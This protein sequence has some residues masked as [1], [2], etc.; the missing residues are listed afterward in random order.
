M[1]QPT[2]ITIDDKSYEID[3]L[4]DVAKQ[5]INNLQAIDQQLADL[6]T[7]QAITKV[8]FDH[9]KAHLDAE[10]ANYSS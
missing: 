5:A 1:D 2:S 4:S 6:A 8:A 3:K 7:K 9:V 10:L